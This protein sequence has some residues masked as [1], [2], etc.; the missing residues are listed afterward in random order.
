[1]S[2]VPA[3]RTRSRTKL[4][5]NDPTKALCS[6]LQ[7]P[8]ELV[9]QIAEYLVDAHA[10]LGACLVTCRSW[11]M[12]IRPYAYATLPITSSRQSTAV[13]ELLTTCP[14][15]TAWVKELHFDF[16]PRSSTLTWF[17]K[18]LQ[19]L[20]QQDLRNLHSLE[21][22]QRGIYYLPSVI[23]TFHNIKTLR[24]RNM[25]LI[26]IYLPML[27]LQF[28]QLCSLELLD[29][30]MLC[31]TRDLNEDSAV[32]PA[33]VASSTLRLETLTYTVQPVY[34]FTEP[35]DLLSLPWLAQSGSRHSLR[36]FEIQ[37]GTSFPSP[38]PSEV[39]TFL[40]ALTGSLEDLTLGFPSVKMW[41]DHMALGNC[42]LFPSDS[43]LFFTLLFAATPIILSHLTGL[44]KL[45]LGVPNHPGVMS[46]LASPIPSLKRIDFEMDF[47]GEWDGTRVRSSLYHPLDTLLSKREA[48]R[49]LED[50]RICYTGSLQDR[51]A[52]FAVL[53]KAFPRAT[54]MSILFFTMDN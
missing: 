32:L 22:A 2:H 24:F 28:P 42:V 29:I 19:F 48:F 50:L 51:P 8:L 46:V 54:E 26:D 38:T 14:A 53:R 6:P 40:K 47:G 39:G 35:H 12:A 4:A 11:Y 41:K 21:F 3:R 7:I 17:L 10:T 9:I 34:G 52:V 18:T 15:I 13:Q 31:S 45:S 16:A 30:L 23:F 1:M 44:R 25:S 36:S 37:M 33:S 27:L 49:S 20:T 5:Q 43:R